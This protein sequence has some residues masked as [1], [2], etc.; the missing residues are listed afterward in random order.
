MLPSCTFRSAASFVTTRADAIFKS[1]TVFKNN[2]VGRTLEMI[3]RRT[4]LEPARRQ[5][6]CSQPA[7][8][9]PCRRLSDPAGALGGRLS[10]GGATD[11]VA[12]LIGQRLSE[13]LGPA[14]RHREQAGR[15]QQYRHRSGHQ[16]T[17][18]GYT[19]L[20][21]NPAELPSTRRSTPSSTSISSA[22]SRRSPASRACRT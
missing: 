4:A 1:D 15:R 12:R 8:E 11:I 13:K 6:A 7:V 14:I 9:G 20:L 21:V 5:S 3:T 17:P 16:R 18:D 22:T 19:L 10:A 2:H